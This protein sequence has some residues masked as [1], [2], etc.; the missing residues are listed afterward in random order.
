MNK[1]IRLILSGKL[2]VQCYECFKTLDKHDDGVVECVNGC[3]ASYCCHCLQRL[4]QHNSLCLKCNV[5]LQNRTFETSSESSW[6]SVSED[7]D[8]EHA[9]DISELEESFS[10]SSCKDE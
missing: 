6:P 9:S 8:S 4:T 2:N 5:T 3:G 10:V 1:N 7:Y